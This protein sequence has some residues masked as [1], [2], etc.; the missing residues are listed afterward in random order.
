M[1]NTFQSKEYVNEM[2]D[3]IN[4]LDQGNNLILPLIDLSKRNNSQFIPKT[5]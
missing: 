4:D 5:I 1:T 3:R 2:N